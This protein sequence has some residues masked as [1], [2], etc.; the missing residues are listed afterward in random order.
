MTF[1]RMVL[2][3][4]VVGVILLVILWLAHTSYRRYRTV[5]AR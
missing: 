2:H 3:L 1:A 4:G 5:G